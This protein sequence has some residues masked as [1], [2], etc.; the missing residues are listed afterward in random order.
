[1]RISGIQKQKKTKQKNSH[2]C[3]TERILTMGIYQMFLIRASKG[4]KGKDA[5]GVKSWSS[6]EKCY[7]RQSQGGQLQ[8]EGVWR[9][10]RLGFFCLM[11][12]EQIQ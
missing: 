11:Q 7:E 2:N 1:M 8:L 9:I 4:R 3:E 5:Y 6:K 10:H 12:R